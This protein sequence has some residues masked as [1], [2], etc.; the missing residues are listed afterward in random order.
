MNDTAQVQ[1]IMFITLLIDK[2]LQNYFNLG[3]KIIDYLFI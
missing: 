2:V 1:N 3:L